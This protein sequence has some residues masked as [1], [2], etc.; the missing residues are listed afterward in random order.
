M[1]TA[2]RIYWDACTWIALIQREQIRD[3]AGVLQ[4]DRYGMCRNVINAATQG[5]M[6]I[7]TSTLC[8]AE[9]CKEPKIRE[10]AQRSPMPKKCTRLTTN[11]LRWRGK[12]TN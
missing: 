9:V 8:Y 3:S 6:E 4:E 7:A 1:A 12:S 5:Q 2:K 10:Q 11:F